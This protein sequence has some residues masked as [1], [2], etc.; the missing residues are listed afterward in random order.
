MNAFLR[1]FFTACVLTLT[2]LTHACEGGD[3]A[4]TLAYQAYGSSEKPKAIV[5]FMHGAV[6]KGGPADYMYRSARSFAESHPDIVAIALLGPGYYDRHG[7]RSDGWDAQ[8]RLADDTD[9]LIEALKALS[10]KYQTK[11]IFVL[12]HSKGAMNMGGILGKEP[13]LISGAVL[14]AGIYDIDAIATSRNRSQNGISGIK[15]V[16]KIDKNTKIV[17]VHG[18]AD[19][20]VPIRQSEAFNQKA[21]EQ[22]LSSQLIV[23]QGEGH[24]FGGVVSKTAIEQLEKLVD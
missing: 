23:L 10:V 18:D 11:K 6:S 20:Q 4:G 3:C 24:D 12:G 19:H 21:Q 15:L 22:G 17:L 14:I 1:I 8:R 2:A 5:V 9:P 13:G 7:K 16:S